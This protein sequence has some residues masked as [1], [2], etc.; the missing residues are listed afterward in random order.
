[1]EAG[2]VA[3]AHAHRRQLNG[4]TFVAITG[5]C[6]KTTTKDLATGLLSPAFRGTSN[7]GSGNCGA[8][9]VRQVLA[10]EPSHHFCIQELGAWGPGTLDAGLS[11][12]QPRIGV[13]LNVRRDHYSG[14]HGLEHTRAEKAKVV[15]CLPRDGLAILNADDPHVA[16]M[17]EQTPARVLT[18]GHHRDADFHVEHVRSPWPE[19][20]S[21]ELCFEG[22]RLPVETQLIGE[23]LAGSAVAAMAIAWG[24]GASVEESAARLAE[25]APTARRMSAVVTESGVSIV[26]DDFKAVSDSLDELLR[27]LEG[28]RAGRKIVVVG[29]ISDYP[30]RS[31]PVYTAFASAAANVAD[32]VVFV[33]E[34]PEGLWGGHRRGSADFLAE[35]AGMPARVELFPTVRDASRFLRGELRRGDLL[36][37]KGSGPS[38]HLERI[39]LG[40]QTSVQ[41]WRAHCGLVVAC[42]DCGLLTLPAEP[43]DPLAEPR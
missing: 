43:G 35:F 3:R 34:R 41:C 2:D 15:E 42:D 28:A 8:D 22:E 18:F 12:V 31:R 40:H 37:L 5:S 11:L 30:G 10:T 23:H 38:D 29:Q 19:R 16:S 32:L 14:F 25:L 6:G 26:R 7:P 36:V 24:L 20:L 33:G 4:V 13:V 39:V 27:F 21:F 17:R 9:V 1:V